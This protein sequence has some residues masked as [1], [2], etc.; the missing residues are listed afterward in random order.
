ERPGSIYRL[1]CWPVRIR[2]CERGCCPYPDSEIASNERWDYSKDR[3]GI[4]FDSPT[5]NRHH[6]PGIAPSGHHVCK[7]S[8]RPKFV[9]V[10]CR[11]VFKPVLVDDNQY[12]IWASSRHM[13]W[14]WSPA[15]S[16]IPEVW[17]EYWS[18]CT[19]PAR[20]AEKRRLQEVE[21]MVLSG[22]GT[23]SEDE[24]NEYKKSNPAL[25]WQPLDAL[26]CPGCGE[27]GVPVGGTFR[28]PP[29]KDARGWANVSE[30]LE[31]GEMFS[32]CLT[33][34]EEVALIKDADIE[35]TRMQNAVGWEETKARRIAELK[36]APGR[37]DEEIR[38]LAR[39]KSLNIEDSWVLL[40]KVE[41]S[42]C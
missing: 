31:K 32:Y 17:E 28:A 13:G 7:T 42:A 20:R 38:R 14:W 29:Q 37:T 41:I 15:P 6:H 36:R 19:L 33:K 26:R 18:I 10:G 16:R 25:W 3:P 4:Q 1:P 27:A 24:M 40:D 8:H 12:D 23:F 11:R 9:C 22:Q 35:N 39:I 5:H 34:E 30:L 2:G 21:Q